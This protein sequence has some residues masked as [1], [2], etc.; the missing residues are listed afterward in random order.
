MMNLNMMKKVEAA[1]LINCAGFCSF[2][3]EYDANLEKQVARDMQAYLHARP[4]TSL[5]SLMCRSSHASPL[6]SL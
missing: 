5:Y 4:P 3:E 1:L 6:A 2:V